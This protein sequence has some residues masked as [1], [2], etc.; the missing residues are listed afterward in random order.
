MDVRRSIS[1]SAAPI[2][3]TDL[4]ASYGSL[5]FFLTHKSI[6]PIVDNKTN[7]KVHNPNSSFKKFCFYPNGLYLCNTNLALYNYS[8][9]TVYYMAVCVLM[10]K[11]ATASNTC[12]S[13]FPQ[14]HHSTLN[15]TKE[16]LFSR[17]VHSLDYDQEPWSLVFQFSTLY[18][19]HS[20]PPPHVD[21]AVINK[22]CF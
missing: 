7:G 19:H 13:T 22:C 14:N 17:R 6:V 3:C 5:L 1:N 20:S 9:F 4:L 2:S 15:L 12:L 10:Y 18:T 8:K 11:A 16:L 21:S